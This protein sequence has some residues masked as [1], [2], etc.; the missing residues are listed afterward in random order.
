MGRFLIYGLFLVVALSAT[1]ERTPWPVVRGPASELPALATTAFSVDPIEAYYT[2]ALY[3]ESELKK[4]ADALSGQMELAQQYRNASTSY[5]STVSNR[6]NIGSQQQVSSQLFN[7]QMQQTQIQFARM[8]NINQAYMAIVINMPANLGEDKRRSY[9]GML[10]HLQLLKQY[11]SSGGSGM[12]NY[13]SVT[14]ALLTVNSDYKTLQFQKPVASATT[15]DTPIYDQPGA[16]GA[17]IND[18]EVGPYNDEGDTGEPV[19]Q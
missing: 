2:S 14:N 18:T 9:K 1:L 19:T 5:G 17:A 10:A 13:P 11:I 15:T 6:Y 12:Y 16:D 7:M 4:T 8:N 3:N